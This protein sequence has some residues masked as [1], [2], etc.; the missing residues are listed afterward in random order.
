MSERKI[1][2]LFN[3]GC[4][5]YGLLEDGDKILV[6]LSGG[7]DSL[8]LL[9]LLALRSRIFKPRFEV[10]AAH[11]IMDNIPYVTDMDYLNGFCSEYGIRL[12]V[13]HSSF[14][15]TTD[16][17][18]TKCFLC[19]WN[20]RKVLFEFA[21]KNGFNKMALGHHQD[22]IITTLL[23]NM[24][25]EGSTGTMPPK[26]RLK[27]YG[28]TIIRPL[29]LVHEDDIGAAAEKMGFRKQERACP[30]ED[31]TKRKAMNDLFRQMEKINPEARYS[32]W[33]AMMN[34]QA[35]RLPVKINNG[36]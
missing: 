27:N 12:H 11:V 19:S 17:R 24:T 2:K 14:D 21:E 26:L 28:L 15:E 8:M 3:K 16:G 36:I 5:D 23:M 9:R 35:D 22:D 32:L 10:E 6:A 31:V 7:K 25:F 30:Y 34:I 33:N 4:V 18:R 29:C 1:E 20:R 13:I